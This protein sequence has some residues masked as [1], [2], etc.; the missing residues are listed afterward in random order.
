MKFMIKK[1]LILNALSTVGRVFQTSKV[2]LPILNNFKISVSKDNL[3]IVAA[4]GET[5]IQ[6]KIDTT[7]ENGDQIINVD[8]E[9][10]FLLNN[11]STEMIRKLAGSDVEFDLIDNSFI[12]ISDGNSEFRLN[13][14]RVKEYPDLDLSINKDFVNLDIQQFIKAV[15]QVSFAASNKEMANILSAVNIKIKD[16]K[17]IMSATDANRLSRKIIDIDSDKEIE[18]NIPSKTL[19]DISRMCENKKTLLISFDSRRATF[20]ID[21]TIVFS[22]LLTGSYPNLDTI[23]APKY[24]IDCLVNSKEL[25]DAMGRVSLLF[26]DRQTAA[27]LVISPNEFKII[28]RSPQFGS[29]EDKIKDYKFDSQEFE[30]SLDCD[31]IV[32]ALRAFDCQYVKLQFTGEVKPMF[33]RSDDEPNLVQVVTPLRIIN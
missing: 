33:I 17:L 15:N 18:I 10:E 27:R 4:N 16:K 11:R 32:S 22:N 21:D 19:I 13:S 3:I 8:T 30:I 6:T 20:K 5:T 9:G 31:Y 23:L 29:I 2:A 1:P 24:T 12:L 25:I 28:A 14:E 7:D 26:I